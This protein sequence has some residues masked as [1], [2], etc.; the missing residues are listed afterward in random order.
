[1]MPFELAIWNERQRFYWITRR[2][3]PI[4]VRV[5]FGFYVLRRLVGKP[6]RPNTGRSNGM[7]AYA[8]SS[9]CYRDSKRQAA[10]SHN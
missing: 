7:V 3:S 5:F 8:E 6:R 10:T 4:L 1:M 2:R 9:R